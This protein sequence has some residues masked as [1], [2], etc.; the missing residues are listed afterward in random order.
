MS[1]FDKKPH[2]HW[3]WARPQFGGQRPQQWWARPQQWWTARPPFQQWGAARPQQWGA[4]RPQQWWA[5]PPF[6]QWTGA[7]PATG[8][9]QRPQQPNR[10]QRMVYVN[11]MI[12]APKVLLID[13]NGEKSWIISRD[14]ALR[15]AAAQW[16]DLVQLA[17]NPLEMIC[18]AKIVDYGKY[19]Y[20]KQKD[21]K[22]K[23]K[24]QKS[25]GWKDIKMS[26]TIWDNDLQLKIK[27]AEGFLDDGYT[28]RFLVRL[29][30]REK[31]FADKMIEKLKGID[32]QLESHGKTQWVKQEPNWISLFLLPK[33]K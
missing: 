26:Y 21:E 20:N 33:T 29:K 1:Q 23:K 5:R 10:D 30:W 13:D 16:L 24:N 15:R 14:E 11:E 28:V 18:T 7:R 3:W 9:W 12:K 31:I 4:A 25:K 6:Q 19:Q 8:G 32:Q 22:E 2:S 27:H 17:Y